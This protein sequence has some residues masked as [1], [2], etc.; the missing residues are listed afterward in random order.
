MTCMAAAVV[1]AAAA[2]AAAAAVAPA[3]AGVLYSLI[4]AAA[5]ESSRAK[6][7]P[8]LAPKVP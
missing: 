5:L 3:V 2:A 1:A 7:S 4:S 6:S 8:S